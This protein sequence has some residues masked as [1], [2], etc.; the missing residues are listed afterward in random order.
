[1]ISIGLD[2]SKGY[3]NVAI[4]DIKRNL[5]KEI[6]QVDDIC[7]GHQVLKKTIS[8]AHEL[9]KEEIIRVGVESTGGYENNFA[10]LFLN[11][12]KE[13]PLEV[14]RLNPLSVKKYTEIELHRAKTDNTSAVD[15]ANYLLDM[16][17]A[18]TLR[19]ISQE[20][21]GLRQ[22]I[23]LVKADTKL[24]TS[25][26]IRLQM[27]LQQS[28][29]ELIQFCKNGIPGWILKLLEKWQ[30]PK[31]ILSMSISKLIKIPYLNKPKAKQLLNLKNSII[32][33]VDSAT[34]LT[35]KKYCKQIL[36]INADV[37]E[38]K[39]AIEKKFRNLQAN[40]LTTIHGIG[41]YSAAVLTVYTVNIDRFPSVKNYIAYFGLDPKIQDSGD[42]IK[43]RHISKRGNSLVRKILYTSVLSCLRKEN[44]PV[45]RQYRRLVK[46]GIPHYS[47]VTACMRK[48]LSIVYGILKSNKEFD[49][50]YENTKKSIEQSKRSIERKK[51]RINKNDS[52]NTSAPI[53]RKERKRR[54]KVAASYKSVE[55]LNAG[56]SATRNNYTDNL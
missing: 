19:I 2:V 27:V 50:N 9:Y 52:L 29:P 23:N 11:L 49:I 5:L 33:E 30:S 44:H 3:A 34:K 43:R 8:W 48:L 20:I 13:Y 28:F 16:K 46:R 6:F 39:K 15:I 55:D 1:M 56:S 21:M 36:E 32:S 31:K 42:L 7:E 26:R 24:E 51:L 12:E 40:K 38:M 54:E 45:N 10:N 47:A 37:A 41:E 25:M 53:S 22:L 18:T 14:Y 17:K 35:I 4:I